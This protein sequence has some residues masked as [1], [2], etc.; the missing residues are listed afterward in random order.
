MPIEEASLK[1]VETAAQ[2][3]VESIRT[4][5]ESRDFTVERSSSW[6]RRRVE[7]E[8]SPNAQKLP[9]SGHVVRGSRHVEVRERGG[10]TTYGED[11]SVRSAVMETLF[12][13]KQWPNRARGGHL[14]EAEEGIHR[15]YRQL[16]A[17]LVATPQIVLLLSDARGW[18]TYDHAH[19]LEEFANDPMKLIDEEMLILL[20]PL[21]ESFVAGGISSWRE[22]SESS[23]WEAVATE[24]SNRLLELSTRRFHSY[25]AVAYLNA[26]LVDSY[27]PID[28]GSLDPDS[29]ERITIE[30]ATDD[31][32]SKAFREETWGSLPLGLARANTILTFRL[33]I[34]VDASVDV[35]EATFP[36]AEHKVS[37][38][39]DV[40]R[41]VHEGDMGVAA[42]RI[43]AVSPSTPNLRRTFAWNYEPGNAPLIPRRLAFSWPSSTALTDGE[44]SE[45]RRLIPLRMNPD[46][47]KGLDVAFQRFRDSCERFHPDDPQQLLDIAIAFEALLLGDISDKELSY[48]LRL[49][50][51][52]W[53]ESDLSS[54][55]TTFGLLKRLYVL[56]SK[57]A[58][59]E[60]FAS[61]KEGDRN[62]L[63]NTLGAAPRLLRRALRMSLEGKGSGRLSQA[64]TGDW[65][66]K[67][68]LS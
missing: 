14:A 63:A 65:W 29:G 15:C 36:W 34:S 56:R 11:A 59:G 67:I 2:S 7:T 19:Y 48:R 24:F 4:L 1:A 40:L 3:L 68:E 55:K 50:G 51:A 41:L 49:R 44:V 22:P 35:Y 54:R 38:I 6:Q 58:H 37:L 12:A 57:I 32:L 26:P 13:A 45:I 62:D 20:E 25:E 10:T 21:E 47:P 39:V 52:R 66:K 9:R 18:K 17:S 31:D 43:F 60:D 33:S 30:A 27:E 53:L 61:A 5:W 8:A 64:E 42:L 16:A 28:L 46:Q 23:R